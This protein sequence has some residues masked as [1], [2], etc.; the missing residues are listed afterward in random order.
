[1]TNATVTNVSDAAQ[2]HHLTVHYPG[3]NK[4][5]VVPAGL[6]IML[7]ESVERSKLVP[8]AHLVVT[9]T[10]L[11]GAGWVASSI[12]MGKDGSVPPF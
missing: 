6:P 5:V 1:M 12:T 4:Q 8:G 9:A 10:R 2:V 11:D 3:G 7:L